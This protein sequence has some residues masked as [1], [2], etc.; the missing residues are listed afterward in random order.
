VGS[1]PTVDIKDGYKIGYGLN[2]L[3]LIINGAQNE[4]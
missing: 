3:Q 4:K 2:P 1:N